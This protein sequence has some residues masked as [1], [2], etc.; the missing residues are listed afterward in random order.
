MQD[1]KALQRTAKGEQQSI[2][3]EDK[4]RGQLYQAP[5]QGNDLIN[6]FKFNGR[7]VSWTHG[8][9]HGRMSL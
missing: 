4:H 9:R 8:K 6:G 3:S 1:I 2:S 7:K 5:F